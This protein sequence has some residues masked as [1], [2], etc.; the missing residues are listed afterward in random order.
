MLGLLFGASVYA[1]SIILAVFLVGLGIGSGVGSLLCRILAP[2]RRPWAGANGWLLARSPGPRTIWAQRSPTG[3]STRR[4]PPTSGSTSSSISP[5]RFGPCCRRRSSGARAFPWRLRR[6]ASKGQDAARLMAGV[7]AANTLGAIV[8]ALGA[9]L[10]LV[11]WV[12]SQRARTNTHWAIH[13]CRSAPSLALQ[14]P[15][16]A[17]GVGPASGAAGRLLILHR[18][19]HR[20]SAHR[21]R[22]LCGDLGRQGRDRLRRR[23]HELLGG[24][25]ELS[26][27]GPDLSRR[28]QDPGFERAARHAAPAHAGTPHDSD[29]GN[30]LAPSW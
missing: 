23:R 30:T 16:G 5:A 22:P 25:L 19:A 9:S 17:L 2:P 20:E 27:R 4:S 13:H 11:A 21:I 24:R 12:G 28:R 26:E 8:G 10:L 14:A 29:D 3:R 1:L 18:P 6:L 7:Y 15:L